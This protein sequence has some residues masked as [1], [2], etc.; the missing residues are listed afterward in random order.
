MTYLGDL[1]AL[2]RI[3]VRR[4]DGEKEG[5]SSNGQDRGGGGETF[6]PNT[7]T[8]GDT[9]DGG[10]SG[11]LTGDEG[12]TDSNDGKVLFHKDS[13]LDQHGITQS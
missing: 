9:G 7:N 12:E 4:Q 6:I 13:R 5:S 8:I 1:V 3:F 10:S 11:S 2:G